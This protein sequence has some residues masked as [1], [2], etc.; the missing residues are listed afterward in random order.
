MIIP[1]RRLAEVT[2]QSRV[3]DRA[4][5]MISCISKTLGP[6]NISL[7]GRCMWAVWKSSLWVHRTKCR[8]LSEGGPD[9]VDLWELLPPARLLL[10]AAALP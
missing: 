6:A 9:P 8:R 4:S 5:W 7:G 10:G 2:A 3:G 1:G